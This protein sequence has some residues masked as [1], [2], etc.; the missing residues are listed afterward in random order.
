M[1]TSF[2]SR[3]RWPIIFGSAGLIVA[4]VFVGIMLSITRQAQANK[5]VRY[6]VSDIGNTPAGHSHAGSLL[7]LLPAIPGASVIGEQE[8]M[9]KGDL[10]PVHFGPDEQINPWQ[11]VVRGAF[12]AVVVPDSGNYEFRLFQ[13][14]DA[15]AAERYASITVGNWKTGP[16]SIGAG[17]PLAIPDV[18]S[19][20]ELA[21][22][23]RPD[24]STHVYALVVRGDIVVAIFGTQSDSKSLSPVELYATD[25]YALL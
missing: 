25:V 16:F 21:D 22:G 3:H 5:Q 10:A 2:T 15:S 7:T 9:T 17:G 18:P 12:R 14:R 19:G 6:D 20:Y 24:N 4:L 13:F 1:R 11:T 23:P 8:P